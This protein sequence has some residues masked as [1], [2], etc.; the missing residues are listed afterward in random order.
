MCIRDSI[1]TIAQLADQTSEQAQ[2]S[3]ELSEA[4]T[5]TAHTQ[6]SLV[7]RFNR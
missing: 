1:S 5:R 6:Y 4:L 7:E 3:A 2:H